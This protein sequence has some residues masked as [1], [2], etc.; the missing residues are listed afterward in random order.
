MRA[1]SRSII[2]LFEWV[3]PRPGSM[4]Y[5][6]SLIQLQ[7]ATCSEIM[8]YSSFI[9]LQLALQCVPLTASMCPL[10]TGRLPMSAVSRPSRPVDGRDSCYAITW[11]IIEHTHA[12]VSQQQF[13]CARTRNV[14]L[15]R[16]AHIFYH[17]RRQTTNP[18]L[19]GPSPR[20]GV[21]KM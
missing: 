11:L 9:I 18:V 3:P 12:L 8:T 20:N 1:D 7:L 16:I 6:G 21:S 10:A 5:N 14:S 13:A 19:I 4:D 17:I 2:A 15:Q